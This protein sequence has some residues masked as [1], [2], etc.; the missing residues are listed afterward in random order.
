[1]WAKYLRP[2]KEEYWDYI[3]ERRDMLV[4]QDVR[5]RKGSFFTPQRW[6]ELSQRYIAEVL[7]ENWQ[8][9]YYVW[10]CAAGTGNLLI[11]L[12]NK[13][14]IYAS[15]LDKA[16]VDVIRDRIENGANLLENHVF[17]FDFLND[18]FLPKA[19][20]GKLPDKLFEIISDEEK[21]KKLIVY[22]NPPYAEAGDSKQRT[23]TGKN[24]DGVSN[25]NKTV[26]TYKLMLGKA[27]NELF[28][29][30]LIRIH[31]EIQRCKIANFAKLKALCA[32]NFGVFR[33][34]FRAKLE[35][36]FVIPADTFDNV[37]GQFPIGFH[38]W[39]TDKKQKFESI[40]ADVYDKDGNLSGEKVFYFYDDNKKGRIN[41]WLRK[42]NDTKTLQGIGYLMAD[43]PDF[44]NNRVV[45][46]QNKKGIRHGIYVLITTTNLIP[47]CIYFAVR[48]VI[49]ENWLN[50][51]DQFLFPNDYWKSD[52]EF[53]TDCF[54]YTLFNNNISAKHG[55]NHWIP[56]IESE[57]NSREKFNSNLMTDFIAG[58]VKLEK[59]NSLF[60]EERTKPRPLSFSPQALA[61]FDA[62]RE[63]WKYYHSQKNID[64]NAS[65]YDIREFFQGRNDTGKMNNKS[66]DEKYNELIGN[67]RQELKFLAKKIEPKVYEYG[68]LM[69]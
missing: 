51:R 63:L 22:I 20:G 67:L 8:D 48:K 13:Y 16:D 15:T 21:S 26:K 42:H 27:S 17:Q 59:E 19:K 7:G 36:L 14:N 29:Q 44:Q 18:E 45:N 54:T 5:E 2:P 60:E 43:A 25:A 53:K 52:I 1:F 50:D 24:K 64:V 62:G 31:C 23:G 66:N 46:I 37:H 49:P 57:V 9:E 33:E 38:V 56:F 55:T 3:I 68:F 4:P 39:D 28:T 61:V 6:V 30:F 41:Q 32:S 12:T 65:F 10:D 58:K 40:S 47:A 69:R 35:K 34:N 11:G